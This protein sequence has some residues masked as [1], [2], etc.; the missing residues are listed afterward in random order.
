MQLDNETDK[1]KNKMTFVEKKLGGLL[2]TEGNFT[3]NN[4]ANRYFLDRSQI[5]TI[6][7]LTQVLLVLMFFAFYL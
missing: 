3:N 1:V 7:L 6:L 2:K 4:P 5:C